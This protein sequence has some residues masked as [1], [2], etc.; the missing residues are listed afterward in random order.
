V[1]TSPGQIGAAVEAYNAAVPGGVTARDHA[2]VTAL[3]GGRPL[4]LP[5][6][7]P[8]TEWRPVA[9]TGPGTPCADLY[10]GIA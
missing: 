9:A 7:V 4:V 10:A 3:F 2:H 5:G 8:V 1:T 6:V